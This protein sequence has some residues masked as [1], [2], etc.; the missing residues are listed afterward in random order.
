L[1]E[2]NLYLATIFSDNMKNYKLLTSNVSEAK[3]LD[4]MLKTLPIDF[5]PNIRLVGE[6]QG[7]GTYDT[8]ILTPYGKDPLHSVKD[9][10]ATGGEPLIFLFASD[11]GVNF[12]YM[13]TTFCFN[14]TSELQRAIDELQKIREQNKLQKE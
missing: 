10:R 12:Q 9:N 4:H 8:V 11:N 5:E 13:Q 2:L 1:K 3:V 6:F 14:Y 7:G